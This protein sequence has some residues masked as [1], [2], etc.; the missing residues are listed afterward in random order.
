M[1]TVLKKALRDLAV[2]VKPAQYIT[3]GS[4]PFAGGPTKE[5]DLAWRKL[6]ANISIRVSDEELSRNGDRTESVALTE[7]GR[8][9]W[10]G[11]FHQLHCLVSSQN[12]A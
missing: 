3:A 1:L 2:Q 4:S 8:M 9:V 5:V 11:V 7:G 10:L 6:L 12:I